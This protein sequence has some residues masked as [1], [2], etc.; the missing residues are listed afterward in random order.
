MVE[1]SAQTGEVVPL[2][3]LGSC[4]GYCRLTK[5]TVQVPLRVQTAYEPSPA[6]GGRRA[7]SRTPLKELHLYPL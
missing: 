3:M 7:Q 5:N 4:S 2:L 6:D 1:K